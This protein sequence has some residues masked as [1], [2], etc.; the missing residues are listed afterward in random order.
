MI[1]AVCIVNKK[2]RLFMGHSAPVRAV[3]LSSSSSYLLSSQGGA[4]PDMRI[5]NFVDQQCLLVMFASFS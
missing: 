4:T 3:A 2:Q 1:V 5:W